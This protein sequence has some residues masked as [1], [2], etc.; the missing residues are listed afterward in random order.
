ML[1]LPPIQSLDDDKN[2]KG[3]FAN[4]YVLSTK[5]KHFV[6]KILELK[7]GMY[8]INIV[9]NFSLSFLTGTESVD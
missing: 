8:R 3:Q 1:Y 6:Y 7:N 2:S 9:S 5:Q 4:K